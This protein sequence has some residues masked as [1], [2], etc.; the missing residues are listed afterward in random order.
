[1]STVK[2]AFKK[3]KDEVKTLEMCFSAVCAFGINLKYVPEIFMTYD[4]CYKAIS[5]DSL[6]IQYVPTRHKTKE[7]CFKAAFR[8]RSELFDVYNDYYGRNIRNKYHEEEYFESKTLL[9]FMPDILKD[10]IHYLLKRLYKVDISLEEKELFYNLMK[11][12]QSFE[13]VPNNLKTPEICRIA[14]K[15]DGKDIKYVPEEKRD[16]DI[17]TTA[18][19]DKNAILQYIPNE[20]KTYE[21]CFIAVISSGNELEYVPD[22]LKTKELCYI[23]IRNDGY[24][25]EYVPES[26]KTFDLCSTAIKKY[27]YSMARK[28]LLEYVPEALVPSIRNK[29]LTEE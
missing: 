6:A 17:C 2:K 26:L 29:Y 21:N 24:A 18:I 1:M 16:F 20:H 7:L 22:E 11:N 10:N 23:A 12:Y 14:V 27:L 5:K 19:I 13:E 9:N 3:L 8:Y 25:L 28:E 4:L 15:Y